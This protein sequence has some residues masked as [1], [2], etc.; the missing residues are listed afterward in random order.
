MNCT[1]IPR[2]IDDC[3]VKNL[4]DKDNIWP[5][6]PQPYF[7]QSWSESEQFRALL[8]VEE[9]ENQVLAA[10][11][12][13]HAMWGMQWN[14]CC[15]SQGLNLGRSRERRI[16]YH[17]ATKQDLIHTPILVPRC[18]LPVPIRKFV[19]IRR[20]RI[21]LHP[22]SAERHSVLQQTLCPWTLTSEGQTG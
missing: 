9:E 6:H 4:G 15:S 16:C 21:Q 11:G 8:T 3:R 18:L 2:V 17:G 12:K 5:G 22:L 1:L 19:R 13:R 7:W 14:P 10:K 20:H